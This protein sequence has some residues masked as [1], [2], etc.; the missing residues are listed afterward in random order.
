[1]FCVILFVVI[2]LGD[3]KEKFFEH[4]SVSLGERT[5]NTGNLTSGELDIGRNG[6]VT[7]KVGCSLYAKVF[8]R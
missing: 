6:L 1:M 7:E 2:S 4:L 5:F 3:L 8:N